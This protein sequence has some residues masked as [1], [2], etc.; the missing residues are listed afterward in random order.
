MG[1]ASLANVGAA[2]R[3]DLGLAALLHDVGTL[4]LPAELLARELELAGEEIELLLDHPKAGL[5]TLLASGQLPLLAL[6][7][8]C[9]HHLYFN[10][11]GY[12]RLVRPRRPHP[13]ARL[14][15]V[16]DTFDLLYTAR[17]SRGM[18]T[19]E[20]TVA[21]LLGHAGSMLDPDW[22]AALRK[23]LQRPFEAQPPG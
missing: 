3:R 11:T 13:A 19:R 4:F 16:A 17:G 10:G 14:V 21:W 18:L 20:G 22:A 6:I 23:I 7:V 9:E 5:E 2:H 8:V 15:T 1:L 12:P